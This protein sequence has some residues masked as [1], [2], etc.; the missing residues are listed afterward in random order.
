[1]TEV[2]RLVAVADAEVGY[3]EGFSNGHWNNLQKYS[4]AVPGLEWS[5]NQAW[6]QTFQSW[7]FQ[8]AGLKAL[9]PVTASCYTAVQWFK[10]RGRFSYYPAVGAQVFFGPGGGSHV[11]VVTSYD[12]D[13]V[14][15]VEGNT[16][17]NGSAEGDGVY[18]RKRARRDD[19]LYGYGYP[20]YAEGSVS[21]DPNASAFGYKVKATGSVADVGGATP[22]PEPPRPVAYEPFPGVQFFK[23]KPRS[24]IVT[25]MGKRLVAVGCSAYSEGPGPKWTNADRESYAKWQRK[26]G[27]YGDDADGWPGKTTWDA[28]K[29]PK[30]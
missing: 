23:K 10:G 20:A 17:D 25:A 24:P 16:N 5:Q 1:M 26:R 30:V 7:I 18:R 2:S 22:S 29:V 28:L 13:Y 12:A 21:A 14:Y 4:P 6:C 8:T 11:G 15:T 3:H 27:F 9:A 19:Y